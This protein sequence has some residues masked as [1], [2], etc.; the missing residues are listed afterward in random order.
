MTDIFSYGNDDPNVTV[1]NQWVQLKFYQS[2]NVGMNWTTG[3][4]ALTNANFALNALD[5]A[6]P[7]SVADPFKPLTLPEDYESI[8]RTITLWF[9]PAANPSIA[10]NASYQLQSLG[11]IDAAGRIIPDASYNFTTG[12][13]ISPEVVPPSPEP[14]SIQDFSVLTDAFVTTTDGVGSADF[15]VLSVE[16]EESFV[17]SDAN[18]GRIV[19]KFSA[20]PGSDYVTG[21]YF[22]AQRKPISR[23]MSR[24]QNIPVEVSFDTDVPWVYVD[25]P[26]LDATP[27]FNQAGSEYFE[28]GYKY[29]V[30]I[31]KDVGT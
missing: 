29:R 25:F 16:P 19:I 10:P 18:S 24:W 3:L 21:Q 13:V 1:G 17:E 9:N 26:S 8:S 11:L 6:T 5:G 12:S 27:V 7:V 31:S 14:I 2:V 20:T 28:P 4:P 22:K 30:K 15:R 23:G